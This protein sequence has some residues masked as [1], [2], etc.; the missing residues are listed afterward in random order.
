MMILV[1]KNVYTN[2]LYKKCEQHNAFHYHCF[3]QANQIKDS[4]Q[5]YM[6][7]KAGFDI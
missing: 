7:P 2:V 5:V 4:A 6:R 3:Q 1:I